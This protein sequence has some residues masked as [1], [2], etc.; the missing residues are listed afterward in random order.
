VVARTLAVWIA[1]HLALLGV[2]A[3]AIYRDPQCRGSDC[4]LT[5]TL[6]VAAIVLLQL[7]YGVI[8]GV[9]ALL[10]RRTA[11]GQGIFIGLAVVTLLFPALCFGVLATSA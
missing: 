1:A 4:G 10:K 3:L 6:G 5:F 8:A 2:L 7:I 11:V 9:V